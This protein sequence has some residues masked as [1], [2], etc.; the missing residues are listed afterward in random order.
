MITKFKLFENDDPYNEERWDNEYMF[1][2]LVNTHAIISDEIDIPNLEKTIKY[3]LRSIGGDLDTPQG[4]L[5]HDLDQELLAKYPDNR[6]VIS[7]INKAKS[8]REQTASSCKFHF[9]D[10]SF[11]RI[12]DQHFQSGQKNLV[13]TFEYHIELTGFDDNDVIEWIWRN[14]IDFR[15]AY[16]FNEQKNIIINQAFSF[17]FEEIL[18][19]F[20][21]LSANAKMNIKTGDNV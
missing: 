3:T 18:K 19:I 11:Y 21:N 14:G 15:P 4:K 1:H 9:N 8:I 2:V 20:D 5:K 16:V 10:T 7:Q 13:M 17:Q 6:L 12:S